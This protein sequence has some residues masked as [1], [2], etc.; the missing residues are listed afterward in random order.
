[1][2]IDTKWLK[3]FV[4]L[5]QTRN[6]SKASDLRHVSQP[7]FSRRIKALESKLNCKLVNRLHQPLQLTV[8]GEI[9][10]NRAENLLTE[11]D[12][13]SEELQQQTLRTPLVFSATHTLSIGVFP[14]IVEH[15]NKLPFTVDTQLKIADADDCTNLLKQKHC[16]YLLAFSDPLLDAFH[17]D[18][19]LLA[20]VKLLPVCKANEQGEPIY[21]LSQPKSSVPYL[22]YQENIYL[23]RV[24]SSLLKNKRQQVNFN[25]MLMSPMADSLK[26]MALKGLGVAWIPEFSLATELA[27]QQLVIAGGKQW[28]PELSLRLYRAKKMHNQHSFQEKIWQHFQELNL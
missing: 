27:T 16:D 23:D 24:V 7:A 21:Q 20:N 1:M 2:N 4:V 8:S 22:A 26:M 15:I 12:L 18:S 6:F 3:D 19:I 10:L 25:K 17:N 14:S 9:F 5:A 11:L 28:Q 13:L